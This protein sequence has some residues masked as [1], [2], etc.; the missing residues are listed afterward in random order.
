M[1]EQ[2]PP[3]ETAQ[4]P[5]EQYEASDVFLWANNLVQIKEELIIELFLFNKNYVVYKASVSKDLRKTLEPLLIDNLL[6][7]VLGGAEEGL[8]VREFEEGE[9]E[10][11][12]LQRTRLKNVESARVVLGWL[13]TQE[14]EIETF[15]EEEHDFK[16][17]K[18][19]LVR[20]SHPDLPTPFYIIKA[21]PAT[22]LMKGSTAW[23]MK[24]GK[25]VP[26]DADGSLQIP[27]DNQLLVLNQDIYVFN[28]AKLESL[29]GYNAK[30]YGIA[31]AKMKTIGES[32]KLSYAEASLEEMV[33]GKKSLVNKLQKLDPT[34]TNQ[35]KLLEHADDLGIELMLD[36]NGAIILMD[37]KD[38]SK[39]VNLLNDDYMESPLTG[40]R[41]EIKS[42]K[43]L[44][45]P[46]EEELTP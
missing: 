15:V 8:I 7:Y 32:F 45:D 12:V 4:T 35:E 27:G 22:A 38:L 36:D 24:N 6:E 31:V 16:R 1:D 14:H 17:I 40:I 39:F 23:L 46:D 10:G 9:A 41:Y 2:K 19:L 26:F 21:L 18:G 30:K 11:N 42:K 28:Q 37:D 13:R 44:K 33:K 20:C 3:E 43:R 29:F 25:F 34:V 5:Q